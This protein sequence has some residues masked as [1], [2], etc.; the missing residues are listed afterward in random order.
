MECPRQHPIQVFHK[1]G[2]CVKEAFI[3]KSTLGDRPVFDIATD[4][5]GNIFTA[6]TRRGRRVQRRGLGILT[7][8]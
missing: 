7:A 4:S 5:K 8:Y 1:D 3:A 2:T 6:E